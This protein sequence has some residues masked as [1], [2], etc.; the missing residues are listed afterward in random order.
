MNYS[1]KEITERLQAQ[2]AGS[3]DL[4]VRQ[5][6]L[7]SKAKR[8]A[9]LYTIEGMVDKEGLAQSSL[10]P[11]LVYD[12]GSQTAAQTYQTVLHTVLAS[13]DVTE[14][15]EEQLIAF[16]TS[17]FAVLALDG[18]DK[19]LAIGVQGYNPKALDEFASSGKVV[20]I[21]EFGDQVND[22]VTQKLIFQVADAQRIA[23][24]IKS[25]AISSLVD[26]VTNPENDEPT[27]EV[28]EGAWV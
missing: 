3:A 19:L 7:K 6:T 13:S 5:F 28:P 8:S 27:I 1:V 18:A 17:G 24:V 9:A 21:D 15:T 26:S 10:N 12:F 22:P 23:G 20:E 2:F 25:A 4:S 14:I 11:L 16:I